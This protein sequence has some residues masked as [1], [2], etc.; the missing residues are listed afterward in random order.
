MSKTPTEI[1]FF[2]IVPVTNNTKMEI[3][4]ISVI[5][6]CVL[7]CSLSLFSQTTYP[8]GVY[9]SRKEL[10]NKKPSNRLELQIELSGDGFS[11]K[12]KRVDK[13]LKRKVIRK[14]I[15][16]I[17]TGEDLY[18]N[19]YHIDFDYGLYF[20]TEHE[21]KYLLY[22][23]GVTAGDGAVIA[24]GGGIAAAAAAGAARWLYAWNPKT[25]DNY[26]INS[27]ALEKW[28]K[29]TPELLKLYKREPHYRD[30]DVLIEYASLR[31][32]EYDRETEEKD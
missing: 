31:N 27:T 4:R 30:M 14:K 16:A 21:G 8:E 28:L 9:M 5:A 13:E 18:L 15:W 6:I 12:V 26:K 22:Q 1:N 25:D 29:E 2:I 23:G 32:E 19:G 10:V 20:K 11:Y 7:L 3:L 17:S 24:F